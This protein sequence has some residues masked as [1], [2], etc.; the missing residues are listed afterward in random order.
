MNILASDAVVAP[1][2]HFIDTL[3]RV[4]HEPFKQAA[5]AARHGSGHRAA[6]VAEEAAA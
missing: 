1:A 6:R 5:N 4:G 3:R 2:E